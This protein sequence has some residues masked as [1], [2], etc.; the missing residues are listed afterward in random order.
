MHCLD[1][2]D[3]PKKGRLRILHGNQGLTLESPEG[4]EW[5]GR[6]NASGR[7]PLLPDNCYAVWTLLLPRR[8]TPGVGLHY[9]R[10]PRCAG[11]ASALAL[12]DADGE[13]RLATPIATFVSLICAPQAGH[14]HCPTAAVKAHLPRRIM[15]KATNQ[16]VAGP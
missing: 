7:L 10:E 13:G 8:A 6:R 2:D 11:P 1:K 9:P 15:K 3:P 4:A 16:G 14:S 5:A 12:A